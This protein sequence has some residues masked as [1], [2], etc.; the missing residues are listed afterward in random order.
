[1]DELD[2]ARLAKNNLETQLLEIYNYIRTLDGK[3]SIQAR[4]PYMI[5]I[6]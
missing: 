4:L 1:M 5:W 6:N 3:S 2:Q